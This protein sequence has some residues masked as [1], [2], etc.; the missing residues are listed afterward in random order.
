M[1]RSQSIWSQSTTGAAPSQGS[2]AGSKRANV[3][4][5]KRVMRV[6]RSLSR[7]TLPPNFTTTH[8]YSEYNQ[9]TIGAGGY[10]SYVFSANGMYDPNIT[11]TGHQPY[12]FD[13]MSA[14]YNHYC[15][16]R[17]KCTLRVVDWSEALNDARPCTYGIFLDDDSTPAVTSQTYWLEQPY[18]VHGEFKEQTTEDGPLTLYWNGRKHFGPNIVNGSQFQGDSATNPTEQSTF[19]LAFN[20]T[21]GSQYVFLVEIVYEAYWTE[22]KPVAQS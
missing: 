15:V 7:T 5:K 17:S 4:A 10:A 16:V 14:L 20:G 8:K 3:S 21:I 6:P 19:V 9:I 18:V 12:Y 11:S 13:T 1:K 22:L 2:K